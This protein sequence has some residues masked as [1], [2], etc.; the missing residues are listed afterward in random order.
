MVAAINE[1]KNP[2]QLV[3][4]GE[5]EGWQ[6]ALQQIVGTPYL[7]TV[8]VRTRTELLEVVECRQADAAVIDDSAELGVDALQMLRMVRRLDMVLPV[9][10]ITNRADRRMLEHALR[11]TAFSVVVRPLELE[12]LLRQIQ[13]MMIRLDQMLRRGSG[14]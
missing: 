9:V 11:L 8:H 7:Q 2:F 12:E 5:A 13:R 1:R 6:S 4:T 3:V 10:L 14:E